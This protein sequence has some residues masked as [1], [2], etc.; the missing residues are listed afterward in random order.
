M[1]SPTYALMWEQWR[2]VRVPIAFSIL[3]TAIASWTLRQIMELSLGPNRKWLQADSEDWGDASTVLAGICMVL[4]MAALLFAH[5]STR[6]LRMGLPAR[7]LTVPMSSLRLA[8]TQ[9][10]FRLFAVA[11]VALAIGLA[12]TLIDSWYAQMVAPF[13]GFSVL[14]YAY[15]SLVATTIG[16]RNPVAAFIAIVFTMSPVIASLLAIEHQIAQSGEV[17]L[18]VLGVF[19]VACVA[20]SVYRFATI[21]NTSPVQVLLLT[22]EEVPA[23]RSS[24]T[25]D[26][27]QYK[28]EWRRLGWLYPSFTAGLLLAFWLPSLLPPG[29]RYSDAYIQTAFMGAPPLVAFI[30][31]MIL[32]AR[33]HRDS[34]TGVAR[35]MWTRPVT[36]QQVVL[37]R[38]KAV[39]LSILYTYAFIGALALLVALIEG[40]LA[41]IRLDVAIIGPALVTAI[42]IGVWSLVWVPYLPVAY[43]L[44]FVAYWGSTF[45]TEWGRKEDFYLLWLPKVA[46]WIGFIALAAYCYRRKIFESRIITRFAIF[47]L[48]LALVLLNVYFMGFYR[49]DLWFAGNLGTFIPGTITLCALPLFALLWQGFFLDRVRHNALFRRLPARDS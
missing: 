23:Y 36:V 14:A 18:Y 4:V 11:L 27:A 17:S 38:M 8:V 46:F 20:L 30:V 33:E 35:F 48:A 10:V 41:S 1:R 32:I 42:L 12:L 7:M 47:C 3:L 16:K 40:E 28:F 43:W 26:A 37:H 29:I 13:V 9:I 24:R 49:S 25:E 34:V 44:V 6:D 31:G 19:V 2:Q 39:A 45:V 15:A 5:S 22:R 21:R